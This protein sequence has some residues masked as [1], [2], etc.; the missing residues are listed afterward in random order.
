MADDVALPPAPRKG[1][2]TLAEAAA[3]PYIMERMGREVRLAAAVAEIAPGSREMVAVRIEDWPDGA[4]H[5]DDYPLR[6]VA[7]YDAAFARFAFTLDH[8]A[9][10]DARRGAR[11]AK[12]S[13]DDLRARY[14]DLVD[15]LQRAREGGDAARYHE[16]QAEQAALL[17]TLAG[18]GEKVSG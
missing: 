5:P 4:K 17:R 11:L 2:Y 14:W 3:T 12:E 6:I 13:T 10:H 9:T 16:L 7:D 18:R 1:A 8:A 15:E